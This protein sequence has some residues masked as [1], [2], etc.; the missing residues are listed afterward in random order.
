[1]T[2]IKNRQ[3]NDNVIRMAKV[4]FPD[5]QVLNIRELDDGFCNVTYDIAFDD[6]SQSI[7]KIS[8]ANRS[9]N[10]S[11]EISLMS[12]EVQ[13]MRLVR[14]HCTVK[15]AEVQYYDTT[16]KISSGDYFFMGKDEGQKLS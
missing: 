12:A 16:R 8:A 6:G 7:L 3:T 9:G 10:T 4:A 5:K 14:G 13:A 15:V 11:N 1:M 2:V